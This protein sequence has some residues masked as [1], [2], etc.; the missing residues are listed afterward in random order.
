MKNFMK[1]FVFTIAKTAIMTCAM[2]VFASCEKQSQPE[3]V[4]VML[5]YTI[6]SDNGA[7]MNGTK[8]SNADVFNEFY[9]KI[10]SGDLVA[11]S[12]NLV[13]K[14]KTTGAEYII[15]GNWSSNDMVTLRTGSY[16]VVGT[17][18]AEGDNIQEKCSLKFA[19]D[20]TID[21]DCKSIT[22]KATYDCSLIIF[23]DASIASLINFNGI[24]YAPLFN[25]SSYLYA[26]IRPQLYADGHQPEAYL[27]G[28]HKNDTEFSIYTGNIIYEIGKY[29]VYNDI[30]TTFAL[31]PM[32]EGGYEGRAINLS[33]NEVANCYIVSNAGEYE[34]NASVIGNGDAGMIQNAYF[35]CTSTTIVPHHAKVIWDDNNVIE[36]VSFSSGKIFF[37]ATSNRGNALIAACDNEANI[38]WSWHIWATDTPSCLNGPSDSQIM[39]RNLGATSANKEDVVKTYGLYYQWG[40]KDPLNIG[41]YSCTNASST[42]GSIAYAVAHPDEMIIGRSNWIYDNPSRELWGNSSIEKTIYDPCPSGY[43]V[44]STNNY[45]TSNTTYDS[46]Y[47]GRSFGYLW[48]PFA[49]RIHYEDGKIEEHQPSDSVVEEGLYH[50]PTNYSNSCYDIV[51]RPTS[52]LS[53]NMQYKSFGESVRCQK[54]DM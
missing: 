32:E 1:Q 35:H 44:M 22:L 51:F 40:R 48:F 50:T 4:S 7:F 26:F 53:N 12:Y 46:T 38:L 45:T 9:Q 19:D 47:K 49:G 15:T 8:A 31:D 36:N 37:T 23:S 2:L 33:A 25:F 34:F 43:A 17:S 52:V 5:T 27:W 13:F 16:S 14:E 11:P 24:G 54:I 21:T 29:Y 42:T 18:T 3:S 6:S 10:I 41:Y 30:N 20:I 39:D 28:K